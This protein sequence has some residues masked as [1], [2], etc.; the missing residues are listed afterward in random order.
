MPAK[1][2]QRKALHPFEAL[3]PLGAQL[4]FI[5][6]P[7]A[8][9]EAAMVAFRQAIVSKRGTGALRVEAIDDVQVALRQLEPLQVNCTRRL[10]VDCDDW[11]ALITSQ[12]SPGGRSNFP[13]P[14]W[15]HRVVSAVYLPTHG[16]RHALTQLLIEGPDGQPPLMGVRTLT[17]HCGS[18][19]WTWIAWGTMQPF[20]Q[21]ARYGQR[22][23]RQRL[24]R[25]LLLE[26]L[27][28]LGIRADD[29]SF[30]GKATLLSEDVPFDTCPIS[31]DA[32]RA[33]HGWVG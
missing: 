5:A 28:A 17:A 33:Q 12:V 4:D 19:K 1:L 18:G 15:S 7:L 24:D 25:D 3:A 10:L 32:W 21:P 23:V 8:D 9:T 20:E 13:P 14:L 27:R 2:E 16:D 30:Y 26:Y 31:I 22:L 29:R 6:L 11:T